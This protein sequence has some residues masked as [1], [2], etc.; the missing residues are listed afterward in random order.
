MNWILLPV[1]IALLVVV[2]MIN[3]KSKH[4][5]VMK[6]V[7]RTILNKIPY[8]E[9]FIVQ[10]FNLGYSFII[11]PILLMA[12]SLLIGSTY[13]YS[14]TFSAVVYISTFMLL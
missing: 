13:T 2:Y 6:I 8:S 9:N 1:I 7:Q 14:F 4:Y 11:I 12:I 5:L 3:Q 10:G